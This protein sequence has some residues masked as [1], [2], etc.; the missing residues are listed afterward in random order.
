M[1]ISAIRS[2]RH[3]NYRL[4]FFGQGVS[5]I[6]TWMQGVAQPWLVYDL[7]GSVVLLGIVGFT[8]QI[9]TFLL[10]PV[11]GVL[12]DRWNRH[13]L[14]VW[15]Q[16]AALVQA[17]ALAA[18][19]LTGVIEVW[20][21]IVLSLLGGLIRA[22]E[23]PIRQS[24]VVEM[25]DDRADLPNAIAM[26]SFLVN[27]SRL[28]GPALAGI[29]IGAAQMGDLPAGALPA[30]AS[31]AAVAGV[32]GGPH[33]TAT[34]EGVCFLLN[35]VSYVAVIL[36]LLAMRLKPRRI[37]PTRSH[38]FTHLAEGFLY[39]WR[40][41]AIRPVLLL[42]GVV[43]LMGVPYTTLM[44]VFAKEI[45]A[46]GPE[47]MGFLMAAVAVGAV[48][49]ALFLAAR[50]EPTG[51]A[52]IIPVAAALFGLGL[53]GFAWSHD[54]WLSMLVLVVAGGGM[55]AQMASSN[56]LLQTVTDEDKRGRVMSFYTMAFMGMGPFGALLSGWLAESVGVQWTVAIG[57][58]ACILGGAAF[59]L[60]ARQKVEA[61]LAPS[62]APA[63]V[64]EP[65]LPTDPA[66]R[67]PIV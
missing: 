29:I 42:L 50:S 65:S 67:P 20:H 21:I 34:G 52:R 23:I 37:E 47:T 27:S 51:L 6:G 43:S 15:A 49:G 9:L 25:I 14:V 56:T 31:T 53:I 48:G 8:G 7:T 30:V 60:L 62:P 28:I 5:L 57:G 3:R 22:F 17:G 26:N 54:F 38:V 41:R 11:A 55:M 63:L 10:A 32:P 46:G 12:A 66:G 13:R 4:F 40:H 2:L 44:P 35:A 64:P 58:I 36:A 45:L 61:A 1:R 59:A 39:A 16:A 24:F 33:P 19:T 18:L